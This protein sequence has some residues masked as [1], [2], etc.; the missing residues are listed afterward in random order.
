MDNFSV[1]FFLVEHFRLLWGENHNNSEWI[2]QR[3]ALLILFPVFITVNFK[4]SILESLF[5][6]Y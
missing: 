5:I 4:K 6:A 2:F 1:Y 3:L